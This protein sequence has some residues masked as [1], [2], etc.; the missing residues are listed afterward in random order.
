MYAAWGG[1]PLGANSKLS[2][3][4]GREFNPHSWMT[5]TRATCVLD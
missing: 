5:A 3:Y 4:F 2:E 1:R